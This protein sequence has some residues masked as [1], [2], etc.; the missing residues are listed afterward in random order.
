VRSLWA[1]IQG[2][3]VFMRRVNGWLTIFRAAD[4]LEPPKAKHRG[5]MAALILGLVA[6]AGYL[7]RRFKSSLAKEEAVADHGFDSE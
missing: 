6:G 7:A 2:D 3:P 4:S 5:R 1:S